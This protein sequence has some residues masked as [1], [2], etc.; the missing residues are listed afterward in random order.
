MPITAYSKSAGRELDVEQLLQYLA[1]RDGIPALGRSDFIPDSW[2]AEIRQD[3]ECPCCFI[4]GAEVVRAGASRK[5]G[6][7]IRQPCFRF[8]TP[9]HHPDC[10]H[11]TADQQ[12][13]IP[14][15]LVSLS[16]EKSALTRAVRILVCA[17]IESGI[18]DQRT[19]R[20]MREW[21][22][23]KKQTSRIDVTL[24]PALPIWIESLGRHGIWGN[25]R[26]QLDELETTA[27]LARVPGTNWLEVAKAELRKR[28]QP[29][30][31]AVERQGGRAF[32][33]ALERVSFLA[34]RHRDQ[35][36]FDPTALQ[37]EYKAAMTLA[38]FM[39]RHLPIL[40]EKK[41]REAARPVLALAAL[42]LFVAEWDL[43]T[44]VALFA[45][46]AGKLTSVDTLLGNIM[47]LNPFH[48]Y[49]AWKKLKQLQQAGISIPESA[50]IK[51]EL[52]RVQGELKARYGY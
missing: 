40:E 22:F 30:V 36:V 42:L 31:E 13:A 41:A 50:D 29:I 19:I 18:F 49:T 28:Y 23:K 44:A 26:P 52:V 33:V 24:D 32:E 14:E 25:W 5:T 10:D 3:V 9:S 46:L 2:R 15:N 16:S 48:D 47:G 6:E 35:S 34:Q 17:G 45:K 7:K 21:F 38:E 11:A 39:A 27:E 43:P 20:N 12:N 51:A 1:Q 8:T 37:R 4:L